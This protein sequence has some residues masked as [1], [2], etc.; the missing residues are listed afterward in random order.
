MKKTFKLTA[1]FLVFALVFSLFPV[2]SPVAAPAYDGS[3]TVVKNSL[4]GIL[5]TAES[6][7][8][9][10]PIAISTDQNEPSDW[11]REEIVAALRAGLVH[12]SVANAG[13]QR[14]TTRL[15]AAEAI[16][17]LIEK[18][19]GET[20]EDIAEEQGWDLN[21]NHF[22][23]TSNNAVTFLKYAGVTLGIG[24]NRY[25]PYSNYTRAQ[26]V[27]MIGRV[28]EAFFDTEA[29][30]ENPFTDVP[31]WA[32]PYVGYAADNGIT[33]GIGGGRFD[34]GGILQN[35]QTAVF[36]YRTYSVWQ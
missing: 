23:D 26:I 5:E 20:M 32:A 22:S 7:E 21:A 2:A 28:A 33:Q 18:A 34:P 29:R 19:T 25:E 13:W 6:S 35:Q 24:D 10:E 1:Y 27:T 30:G 16:T 9:V 36:I 14:P 4:W 3:D 31:E 17:L 11:A 12:D 8:S 15:A